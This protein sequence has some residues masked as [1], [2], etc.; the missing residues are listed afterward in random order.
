MVY[1][2]GPDHFE[3]ESGVGPLGAPGPRYGVH[4]VNV[5]ATIVCTPFAWGQGP[6]ALGLGPLAAPG[7]RYGVPVV[8]I[9][10]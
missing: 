2:W 5:Y 1:T 9:Y 3:G 8:N 6:L 7:P 4:V 10:I